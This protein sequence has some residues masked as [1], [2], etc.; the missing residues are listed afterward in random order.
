MAARPEQAGQ[1]LQQPASVGSSWLALQPA[2]VH[3]QHRLAESNGITRTRVV[4]IKHKEPTLFLIKLMGQ[5]ASDQSHPHINPGETG[6][7]REKRRVEEM[8]DAWKDLF[9]S[10][11]GVSRRQKGSSMRSD[12]CHGDGKRRQRFQE[13]SGQLSLTSDT[14][15]QEENLNSKV[16]RGGL[17]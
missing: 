10:G 9:N 4:G 17:E 6:C 11:W 15:N 12:R 5:F 7:L 2:N 16:Q 14:W 1:P 13:I 3:Q 8:T